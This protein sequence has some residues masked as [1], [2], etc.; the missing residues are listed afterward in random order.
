[1]QRNEGKDRLGG[2]KRKREKIR[3][4]REKENSV[5]CTKKTK[6]VMSGEQKQKTHRNSVGNYGNEKRIQRSLGHLWAHSGHV[7]ESVR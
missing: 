7:D 5:Q 2:H 6:K 1:M 4:R 3:K